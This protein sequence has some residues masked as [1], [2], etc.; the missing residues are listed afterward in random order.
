MLNDVVDGRLEERIHSVGTH[1]QHSLRRP[2]DKI[3]T[4]GE[5]GAG[6]ER[7]SGCQFQVTALGTHHNVACGGQSPRRLQSNLI[8]EFAYEDYGMA[9]CSSH[10]LIVTVFMG[11]SRGIFT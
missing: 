1:A 2:L 11:D 10:I 9:D 5:R 6:Q 7:A 4:A 8:G 3:H